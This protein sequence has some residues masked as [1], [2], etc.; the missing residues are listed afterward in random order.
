MLS[1]LVIGVLTVSTF[2]QLAATGSSDSSTADPRFQVATIKP[3]GPEESR[4]MQIRGNRFATTDTSVVDLLKYAY[5]FHEQEIV[6]G[7][8]W[9]KAQKFDVVGDPETQTRPSSD[10]FKKMVQNLLTDR[11]HLVAH[12]EMKGLSVFE[13]V[14]AKSGPTLTRTT[15]T[16]GI[17]TVGYLPGQLNVGNATITD[18]AMFL[19][20]FVTD[21]PVFDR[22]GITGKYDLTLRWTPD[23]PQTEGSRQEN[24]DNNSLPGFFTAIQEQLGLK[25]QEEKRRAQVFVVDHVD[26][27]SE[28]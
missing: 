23:E 24:N 13:I 18:L 25:L 20:R 3:S 14:P 2:G 1:S 11:F 16:D 7:P 22:T 21:R 10:D 26:M 15:R 4:T 8:K 17:P 27:P 6:G 5:G 28:N 12:Y 19:Q 9:L